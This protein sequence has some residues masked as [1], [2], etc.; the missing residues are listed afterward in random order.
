LGGGS[1]YSDSSSAAFEGVAARV[2][3]V[4]CDEDARVGPPDRLCPASVLYVRAAIGEHQMRRRDAFLIA[5]VP[6]CALAHHVPYRHRIGRQEAASAEVGHADESRASRRSLVT[7]RHPSA[8]NNR[9][10]RAC[11][12]QGGEVQSAAITPH[13]I[14]GRLPELFAFAWSGDLLL[15]ARLCRLQSLGRRSAHGPDGGPRGGAAAPASS[16]W[17]PSP[18][19]GRFFPVG[20]GRG[21]A[22]RG[23]GRTFW[24]RG[25]AAA[26]HPPPQLSRAS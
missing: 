19:P 26:L 3:S 10:R 6:A 12:P 14:D 24:G 17:R 13:H 20:L 16:P 22:W 18:F 1:W 8:K 25:G 9:A 23:G 11:D 15:S 4:L 21:A 2:S 7:S 5:L